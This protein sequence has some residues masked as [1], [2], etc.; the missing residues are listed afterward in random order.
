MTTEQ[1]VGLSIALLI[2]AIG[3]LGSFLPALP[4]TPIV[5]G[6]AVVHRLYFGQESASY[7]V[8][9]LLVGLSL[10]ALVLDYI[11]TVYGARKMGATW[12][13]MLGAVVGALVGLFFA[14]PGIL[15][16]PFL[17][18]AAFEVAGGRNSE[19]ALRA[20]VGAVIGIFVGAFGKLVCCIAMMGL[21]AYSVVRASLV[22][23]GA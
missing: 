5:L 22:V 19:E 10:L 9:G 7:L 20:G 8:L 17:G 16:G 1:I 18:A 13:G 6:A 15:L 3:V 12:R 4:S 23:G 11:A 21:F 2:M 14:L